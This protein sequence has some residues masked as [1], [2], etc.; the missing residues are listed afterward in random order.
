[1][2][3]C[4][5]ALLSLDNVANV[6]AV[7]NYL[8]RTCHFVGVRSLIALASVA[9][10]AVIP[11][12]AQ[13]LADHFV[14][15][16]TTNASSNANDMDFTFYTEDKN[17]DIDWGNDGM[18]ETLGVSGNQSHTFATAGEH[19]IRFRN[20]QDIYINDQADK[21]KYTSIEQWGTSVWDTYM[22]HAFFGASNLIMSS[23]AGTLE[24]GTVTDMNGMFQNAT[25]FDGDISGW[26]VEAVTEM[27]GMFSGASSFNG[28]IDGWNTA[29]VTEMSEMFSGATAFNQN[30]GGWNTASVE[31]MSD[32]FSEATSFNGGISGWNTASVEGMAFM[33]LGVTLSVANYD[34]LLVGWGQTNPSK[35]SLFPWRQF[36]V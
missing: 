4:M 25:S 36:A 20:L 35:W 19:T 5:K 10:L 31:G 32:M 26:N 30:L 1:M 18:F 14:L 6:N 22:D 7:E 12:T 11:A 3:K 23:S 27:S 24:M 13:T 17:Y 8:L 28:D 34:S 16:V 9:F 29:S 2:K 21:A 33:F 15:K